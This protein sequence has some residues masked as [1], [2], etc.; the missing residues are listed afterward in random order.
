M[1]EKKDQ[2]QVDTTKLKTG[3]LKFF[4]NVFLP[5][6]TILK[7]IDQAIRYFCTGM[8]VIVS[9]STLFNA[10]QSTVLSFWLACIALFT[11]C[12][13]IIVGVAPNIENKN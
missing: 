7:R 5:T 2:I 8:I 11:G 9:T 6:P 1:E 13:D 4:G 10:H 12:I 3:R